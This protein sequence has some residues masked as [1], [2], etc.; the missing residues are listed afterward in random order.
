[1]YTYFSVR[2]SSPSTGDHRVR[3]KVLVEKSLQISR[4][5]E[6]VGTVQ[7]GWKARLPHSALVPV[8][9]RFRLRDLISSSL[10]TTLLTTQTGT[11][12]ELCRFSQIK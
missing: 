10:L 1:M 11:L 3:L 2:I 12:P 4:L 6:P 7:P 5:L 9:H 8:K